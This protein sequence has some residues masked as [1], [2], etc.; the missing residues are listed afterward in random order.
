MPNRISQRLENTQQLRRAAF[1]AL[2]F[3]KVRESA[4]YFADQ[5]TVF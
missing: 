2:T 3:Q 1:R 4:G 5:A